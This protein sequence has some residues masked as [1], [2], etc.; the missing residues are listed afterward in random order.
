MRAAVF[1]G[2]ED[3]RIEDVP[4]PRPGPGEVLLRN[5]VALTCGTDA[6]VFRRGY[7]ARMLA[8]PAP[9]G[10]E[11]AGMVETVGAGVEG[12][13]PGMRVVWANS[14]PCDA[15]EY[16]RAGRHSLC[17]DLLFWNG[18][19]AQFSVLPARLVARNLIAVPDG[20]P[21]RNAAMSEPLACVVRG[22][23]PCRVQAGQSV[24]VIGTGSIGLMFVVL[25]KARGAHVIVAGRGAPGLER[26]RELGADHAVSAHD[27][28]LGEH[29]RS[30]SRDGRGADVVIEAVGLP[31]TAEAALHAVRKG[32]IV[33]VFGGSPAD[34]Q[35]R[36]E[37]ARLHYQ[38][39]TVL[40]TFHHTP[41][42]F[43][44]ALRLIVAGEVDPNAFVRADAPLAALP[45][46]LRAMGQG[47][48]APKTAILPWS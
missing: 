7:H 25:L 9:F 37:A 10:H 18:G 5:E 43:R 12:F 21:L 8:L 46:V 19:Y 20:V 28:D 48:T 23:E 31:E 26:A 3:V 39:L 2:R 35:V 33:N 40:G 38:E 6:K 24:A 41:E 44:E 34:A 11:A 42:A 13:K 47:S 14:A 27:G 17:D 30:A 36:L 32:G 29:I 45:D 16:C 15:C 4:C 22:L 1:H